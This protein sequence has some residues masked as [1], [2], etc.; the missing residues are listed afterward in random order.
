MAEITTDVGLEFRT[1]ILQADLAREYSLVFQ[2][3]HEVIVNLRRY[4]YRRGRRSTELKAQTCVPCQTVFL[5]GIRTDT[6]L[7]AAIQELADFALAVRGNSVA[8]GYSDTV[9]HLTVALYG[10]TTNATSEERLVVIPIPLQ[11]APQLSLAYMDIVVVAV[12]VAFLQYDV[13]VPQIVINVGVANRVST[14]RV[15]IDVAQTIRAEHIVNLLVVLADIGCQLQAQVQGCIRAE[16]GIQRRSQRQ[17]DIV[18]VS[19]RYEI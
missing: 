7:H 1:L 11:R 9:F 19:G 16:L 3:Q 8:L 18:V 12:L 6:P 4:K 10:D 17:I 5:D 2:V 14:Q 15:G 13:L